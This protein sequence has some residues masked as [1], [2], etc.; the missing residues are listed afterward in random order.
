MRM[1]ARISASSPPWGSW[2]N[3]AARWIVAQR[4]VR[5]KGMPAS[6]AEHHQVAFESALALGE[7]WALDQLW[8]K[9]GFV[10]LG[11]VFRK[12]RYTT[13]IEHAIRVMVFNQLSDAHSKLGVLHWLQMV[14]MPQ[15]DVDA[16]T[17]QH[18]LRTLDAIMDHQEA[19]DDVVAKLLRPLVDRNSNLSE[20]S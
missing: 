18:L 10:A 1:V 14:S 17:H 20:T 5:A 6:V 3:Q 13:P 11:A 4:P 12:A 8:K 19:A 7:V 16:L 2:T 9:L 15:I